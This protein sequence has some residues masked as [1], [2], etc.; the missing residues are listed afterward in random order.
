MA[1]LYAS[2][3]SSNFRELH[4]HLLRLSSGTS[5]M[6]QY[7]LRPI[8]PK[9]SANEKTYLSGYGVTLDLKKMDYLA[10]DDRL[11]HQ[12]S[13]LHLICLFYLLILHPLDFDSEDV[14]GVPTDDEDA[15]PNVVLPLLEQYPFN[16]TLGIGEPLMSDEVARRC[17]MLFSVAVA[18]ASC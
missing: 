6:V 18:P 8:P 13:M 2:L 11:T 1:I 9:G 16:T 14:Q 5:P 4:S 7:V 3:Q 12:K 10:L 15:D 17:S